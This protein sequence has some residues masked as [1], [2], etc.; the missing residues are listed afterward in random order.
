MATLSEAREQLAA[1]EAASL[2]IAKGKEHQIGDRRIRLEDA[3]RVVEMIRY[4]KGEIARL[5]AAAAGAQ[6]GSGSYAVARFTD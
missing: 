4:W 2:A 3:N 1:W 5:E 6:S